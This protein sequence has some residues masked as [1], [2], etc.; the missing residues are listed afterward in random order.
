MV[1][2]SRD[3]KEEVITPKENQ[4]IKIGKIEY[5]VKNQGE[6]H[7]FLLNS[8][9]SNDAIFITLGINNKEGWCREHDI[10][11]TGFGVFPYMSQ[12]DLGK[13]IILLRRAYNAKYAAVPL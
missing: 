5:I 10:E 4:C 2:L 11:V 7:W 8:R 6:N 1:T 3:A 13:A 9:G 12:K